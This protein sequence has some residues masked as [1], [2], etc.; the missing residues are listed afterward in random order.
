MPSARR[1]ES[2]R[3]LDVHAPEKRKAGE[4]ST[5][6]R[7]SVCEMT[8]LPL[9]FEQDLAAYAQAGVDGIG[10]MEAKLQGRSDA[11]VRSQIESA[12]LRAATMLPEIFTILPLPG[13]ED[14]PSDPKARIDAICGAVKRTA[15]IGGIGAF[16][17]TGGL[18]E[19]EPQEAR[20]IVVEGLRTIMRTA[21][22]SGV[23][24]G[25]EPLSAIHFSNWTILSG[26][27]E[28]VALVDEVGDPDLKIMYDVW[29]LWD[30]PDVL[31]LTEQ[32]CRRFMSVC[33][34]DDI[35]DSPRGWNDR[36]IPGQGTIDLA[37]H[38]RALIRG[39]FEG[40]FELEIISDDGSFTDDYPDSIWRRDPQ[41]VIGES[42]QGFLDAWERASSE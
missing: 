25:I 35:S 2:P 31:R 34:V 17:G 19:F 5:E 41:E 37:A 26:I 4:M 36:A 39:G 38:L 40:W 23:E 7:F 28:S 33:H 3:E 10:L 6:P 18:S 1:L 11:E 8:T 21:N 24:F 22:D 16:C 42:R 27:A 29:H 12:G 14:G 15:E 20:E 13:L 32:H 30:E 9:S